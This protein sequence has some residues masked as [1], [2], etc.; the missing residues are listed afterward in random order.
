[1]IYT[2]TFNPALDYVV[3]LDE[4][5]PGSLNRTKGEQLLA[6]G[7]GINVST[8]LKNLDIANIALGF[9]AGFTGRQIEDMLKADGCVTDFIYVNQGMSRINV[10][11]RAGSETE[12]NGMGP[13]IDD[14]AIEKLYEKLDGLTGEDMLV[15]AGSIPSALPSSIY[16]DIMK[17]LSG[18]G[19]K[20][21]VDATGDLL[22]NVL[23]YRPFLIKPNKYELAEMF[24]TDIKTKE[25]VIFYANKLHDKGA[26]NVLISMGVEGAILIDEYGVVHESAAPDGKVINTVGS[27]D[28]M[29]AGFI[30]GYTERKDYAHALKLGIAAGSASAFS[31]YLATK[32]EV[33]EVYRRA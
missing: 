5:K 31:K 9:V 11:V 20:F 21:V 23:Q 27:G 29:V 16:S 25:E 18:K 7:K 2:V 1:M 8:V 14:E 24:D 19:I 30:A 4:L 32:D 17:R 15:L 28:S 22:L 26:V 13:D 33:L 6:G 3:T 10:K 12:I